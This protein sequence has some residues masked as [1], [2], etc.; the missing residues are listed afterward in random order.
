MRLPQSFFE[1]DPPTPSPPP[2]PPSCTNARGGWNI[3]FSNSCGQTLDVS[4]FI[5]HVCAF[6]IQIP[7]VASAVGDISGQ[8]A[9]F[10]TTDPPPCVGSSTGTATVQDDQFISITFSGSSSCCSNLVGTFSGSR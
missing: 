5:D 3:D 2:P 1:V 4:I 9:S 10:T 7:G 6:S 8:R